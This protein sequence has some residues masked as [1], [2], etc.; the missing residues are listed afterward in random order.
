[1]KYEAMVFIQMLVDD[2]LKS[3]KNKVKFTFPLNNLIFLAKYL[4]FKIFFSN[5]AVNK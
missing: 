3:L 5:F 4:R 1:M 2:F